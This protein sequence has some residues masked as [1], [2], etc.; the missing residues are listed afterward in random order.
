MTGCFPAF[1]GWRGRVPQDGSDHDRGT[2]VFRFKVSRFKVS[3]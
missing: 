2:N 3:R 1:E